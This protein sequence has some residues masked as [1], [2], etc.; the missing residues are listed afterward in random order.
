[1]STEIQISLLPEHL[2]NETEILRCISQQLGVAENRIKHIALRK[3]S[4]DA[5]KR[6]AVFYQLR[7]E[8]WIDEEPTNEVAFQLPLQDVSLKKEIYIVG[9][10]PAGL[11]A[12]LKCIELG[13]KPIVLERGK[14]VRARRR[15]LAA[16]NKE[17]I[18]NP[19][20]NYC[21]GEGGA[22]TFSDGKLYTRST[23]RGDTAAVLNVLHYFGATAD[24]TID[25]HPH[26]GTNKLPQI[27]QNMRE[28]IVECGGE[29]R[30][31]TKL[32]NIFI[33][34][35]KIVQIEINGNEKINTDTLILA[36]GHSARDIFELLHKNN[37]LIEAKPF[38][39][40]LRVEHPQAL[41]DSLQYHCQVRHPNLPAASYSLVKQVLNKGVYSFCMCPGGIICPSTTEENGL[42]VNG[43][44]PSKRD[45]P[46]ANSGIV[47]EVQ[48]EDF[49]SKNPSPLDGLLFQRKVEEKAA[50]AGGGK[51]VAP[52][53]RLSDFVA[54][55]VSNTLPECSYL[56]G[57]HATDLRNV[58][59]SFVYKR[60]QEG[61]RQFGQALKGYVSA[62]AV[63]VGV[64]SRTSSP[65]RIPRD[66]ETLMHPQVQGL[67][68]CG[69]GAGY[70]GGIMSAA[71]DG[72]KCAVAVVRFLA[73]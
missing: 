69:E 63:V 1:M 3:R 65:V 8:V 60:L 58:L 27:I 71:I 12:A 62:E 16:L 53:A 7:Y 57:L 59:P 29:V 34:H 56:P 13:Y 54:G 10:G 64:E 35:N 38:A 5:R 37:I 14:D 48:V 47:V 19:D 23:K 42:V 61:F 55:K 39:L 36:T 21:F 6:T 51:Q 20:S 49:I 2:D 9:L 25:A 66:I 15:D 72:Q 67:F 32:T 4:V 33:Q 44:S 40:G 52:A 68:P 45:S 50:W 11:F 70:A 41:I 31:E 28:K 18:V 17:G 30:F 46:F 26:I 22:G 24:I 43:W 73:N